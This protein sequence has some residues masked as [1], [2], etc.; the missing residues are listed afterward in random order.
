MT[1]TRDVIEALVKAIDKMHED[2]KRRIDNI[3]QV[4]GYKDGDEYVFPWGN[5]VHIYMD[6]ALTAGKQWLEHDA[7]PPKAAEEE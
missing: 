1:P 2:I 6:N 7:A 5:G 4:D 3:G